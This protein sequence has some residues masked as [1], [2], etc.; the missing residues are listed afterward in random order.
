MVT[1]CRDVGNYKN[2]KIKEHLEMNDVNILRTD[3]TM[4]ESYDET[5]SVTNDND[6][7]EKDILTQTSLLSPIDDGTYNQNNGDGYNF[8]NNEIMPYNDMISVASKLH[9]AFQRNQK[10][11]VTVC[12]SIVSHHNWLL[13]M[14]SVYKKYVSF[15][16]GFDIII[17]FESIK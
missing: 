4:I 9:N 7:S 1:C 12:G 13:Y 17:L 15:L 16:F 14:L 8:S 2:P 10:H 3:E 6:E 11:K 5:I